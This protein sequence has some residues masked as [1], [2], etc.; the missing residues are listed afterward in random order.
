MTARYLRLHKF[1]VLLCKLSPSLIFQDTSQPGLTLNGSLDTPPYNGKRRCPCYRI[2]GS[3]C[4]PQ[5]G[6]RSCDVNLSL[7][8]KSRM[9][10]RN[11]LPRRANGSGQ[12][13][14]LP[15]A[16][17]SNECYSKAC[18]SCHCEPLIGRF[19][20]PSSRIF[21]VPWE[22]E[23]KIWPSSLAWHSCFLHCFKLGFRRKPGGACFLCVEMD[24]R[25][26]F[27]HLAV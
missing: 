5:R 23:Y 8:L 6:N 15:R 26:T 11:G 14:L 10:P 25:F 27:P 16:V 24:L 9:Q 1:Q 4:T 2:P 3:H 12:I 13:D 21:F 20:D 19:L 17:P 7:R 18:P 22:R